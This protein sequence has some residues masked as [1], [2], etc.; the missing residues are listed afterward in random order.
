ME[1]TATYS[2]EDNKLRLYP[3]CRLDADEYASIKKLGFRWAGKQELF[4]APAWT[5]ARED[6]LLEMCGEIG[7]EDYSAADRS[8]DRA[9]RFSDYRDKRRSE[10]GTRAD[11]FD[12][13]PGVY[14]CQSQARAERL[15]ARH[16]RHRFHAV[17]QWSKAEYW[18]LRTSGVISH[19]LH[20]LKPA[21]RRS[22]ILRL[23]AEQRKHEKDRQ[24]ATHNWQTWE[25]IRDE[26]DAEKATRLAMAFTGSICSFW[27]VK[28]P[29][30]GRD[31]SLYG[32]LVDPVDPITGHEAA[33]LYFAN[34]KDPNREGGY[35][36]RWTAHYELRLTYEKAM[37]ANEGGTAA[38]VDIEPGGWFGRH[39]VQKVHRSTVTKRVVSISV[40]GPYEY[41][42]GE[43][44]API[45][46]HNINIERLG[47]DAY[48]P[49]TPEEREAFQAE[50]KARKAEAKKT[51]PKT[52]S[53]INP[54]DEDAE[55]L[56]A[57][58]NARH[59]ASRDGRPFKPAEVYRMTQ[60]EYS[61]RSKGSYSHCETRT[62]HSDGRIAR[63]FTGMYSESG[64]K[65]DKSLP[66]IV[67]KIRQRDCNGWESPSRVILITDKPQKPLPL[68][69]DAIESMQAVATY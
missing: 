29:R 62:L 54:T 4:V 43:G 27:D 36:P 15:A 34:A 19:A 50:Q 24:Q 56:Q 41:H 48:R 16:D 59:E 33:S 45:V 38:E 2:P 51:A 65:Y 30:T 66:A 55:R 58:W 9:E 49:P 22:R 68:D 18:Q 13:G 37:L 44:P 21:V 69:W 52:P 28:H 14:G 8:A 67:C 6:V 23:E 5:P 31:S 46:L 35:Y 47:S 40:Y 60:D 1:H 12:A 39:Q 61:Q 32:L 3:A 26:P 20:K 7:D 64:S 10:A 63:R 57:I 17:S 25:R 42:R 11:A 53:L